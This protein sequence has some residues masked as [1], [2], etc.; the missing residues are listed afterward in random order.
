[1][2]CLPITGKIG[3]TRPRRSI[4]MPASGMHALA[5]HA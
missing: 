4:S 2:H 1:M 3:Q 5:T